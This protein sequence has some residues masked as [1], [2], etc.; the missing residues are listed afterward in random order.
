MS[1]SII[2][3]S[4]GTNG[5]LPNYELN[6]VPSSIR[7]L[8]FGGGYSDKFTAFAVPTA[9]KI[10]FIQF[11]FTPA[12]SSQVLSNATNDLI[13]INLLR[14]PYVPINNKFC[15]QPFEESFPG[16][17]QIKEND[18]C[19]FALDPVLGSYV[20]LFD[21]QNIFFTTGFVNRGDFLTLEVIFT[22]SDT[23][24]TS[25]EGNLSGSISFQPN[26]YH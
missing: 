9:G 13:T 24:K 25:L 21:T 8:G 18:F 10:N 17:L 3:F 20:V 6:P 23:G 12:N 4:S 2:P 11:A 5:S 7:Y 15:N 26:C 14:A 1:I 16:Q 19:E 22:S